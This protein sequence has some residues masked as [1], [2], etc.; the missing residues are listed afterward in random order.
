MHGT[1]DRTTYENAT[2]ATGAIDDLASDDFN[3]WGLHARVGYQISPIVT[4][5]VE[6][7]IDDRHY[8]GKIDASGYARDSTGAL[9]RAGVSLS[10]SNQL[11]GEFSAGYGERHYEDARLPDLRGPLIDASIIWSATPLT[12]VTLK[13]TSAL[14]DTTT[15]GA[16]G[17]L[18]RNYSID[19]SHALWRNLTLGATASFGTD[20]YAGLPQHDSNTNFALR[21]DYN[22]T[23]DIVLR[24]SASRQQYVSNVPG[25]NYIANVFMLGL[26]LQR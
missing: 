4:P 22:V 17:A 11:T 8:D 26:R 13:T 21:A 10:L 9:A 6:S 2:L 3:D 5:F 25:S 18:S 1:L 12:T 14:N 16:S 7:V 23:R 24:A 19:I 15:P 20:V